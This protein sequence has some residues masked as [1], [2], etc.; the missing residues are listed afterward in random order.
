MD[1]EE[2]RKK[3]I[4]EIEIPKH[5]DENDILNISNKVN[6]I[7]SCID[8]LDNLINIAN[9]EKILPNDLKQKFKSEITKIIEK[10]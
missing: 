3:L 10:L 6:T 5:D 9:N 4:R 7:S 2:I 1:N 8:Y